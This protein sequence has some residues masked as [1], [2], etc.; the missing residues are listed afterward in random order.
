MTG[1]AR[2][3]RAV[4]GIS[5][6]LGTAFV[7]INVAGQDLSTTG[8]GVPYVRLYDHPEN[9]LEVILDQGDGQAF[10]A[11]AQD[12]LLRRPEIFRAGPA[13]ASY[14]AQRPLLGWATWALSAGQASLVPLVLTVL[15][16]AG[17]VALSAM[18]A[19]L[20][21]R[22]GV[23]ALWALTVALW[24]GTLVTLDWT[25]PEGLATAAGLAG[26]GLWE[27]DRRRWSVVALV[28]AGLLR[29]SLLLVPL[30]MAAHAV[31]VDRRSWR[32]VV[33]LGAPLLTY[34]VWVGV[35]FLRLDAL[36]SDAGRG[37]LAAPFTGMLDASSGWNAT[38]VACALLLVGLGVGA[39]VLGRRDAAGWVAGAFVGA[40]FLFGAEVW[41]RLE[42]FSR[43][44][45]P[46]VAFAVLVIV[47]ARARVRHGTAR[48]T[49]VP[50]Q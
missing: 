49:P 36:P 38:D 18:A 34:A 23:S 7:L 47:P 12:P 17:F 48:T 4:A 9:R 5:L 42:D 50:A 31:V 41:A 10:A 22:R 20:L 19:W 46:V 27:A 21:V 33:P 37:R 29:E 13:E 24:P 14:R 25:G 1:T 35:V 16:L 45:L 11:L 43:V 39:F 40:S 44:L 30:A 2:G 15:A 3:W 6:V 26:F 8:R 32:E 28:A